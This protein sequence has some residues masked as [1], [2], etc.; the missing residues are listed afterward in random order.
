VQTSLGDI[1][2]RVAGSI[3][4]VQFGV[5]YIEDFPF[6]EGLIPSPAHPYY[7]G[8]G[9]VAYHNQQDITDDLTA[10]DTALGALVRPDS[11]SPSGYTAIGNGGD[12]NESQVEG[13]YQTATGEGGSWT[14]TVN[15]ATWS[16]PHRECNAIPD[17]LRPRRGYPCFRPGSLPIVVMVT[18][19][20]FHN[21]TTTY[22]APYTGISPDP[23]HLL[24]A[25]EA[26]NTLGA[27][28]IGVGVRGDSGM[29]THGDHDFMASATGSVDASGAPLVYPASLGQVGDQVVMAIETLALHTPMDVTTEADDW[30]PNPDGVDATQ[31][32]ASITAIE[33]FGPG[34]GTG[35]DHHDT[36]TFYGVVPGTSL[37]F[38]VDFV[39]D[40]RMPTDT[41]QVFRAKIA[42][43]GN[44]SARLDERN[45]YIIVPPD[46]VELVF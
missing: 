23:H 32:I 19:V 26:F 40:F 3:S 27:R 8:D 6:H 9:D 41:A 22:S 25:A 1:A 4:D 34:P 7:G 15:G 24:D 11:S 36:T 28:Y 46:H 5:G 30:Q 39:N 21:G 16:L 13:L 35:Y 18:D 20:E 29:W 38:D 17:E 10:I 14:F 45:V 37:Q 2:S 44:R 33:G 43:I 31:F 42:V 12:G